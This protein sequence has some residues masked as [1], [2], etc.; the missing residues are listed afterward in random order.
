MTLFSKTISWDYFILE[1][2]CQLQ[3][4]LFIYLLNWALETQKHIAG[5]RR[6]IP[7]QIIEKALYEMSKETQQ[8]SK[9]SPGSGASLAPI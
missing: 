2:L 3:T 7:V 5:Q 9:Q 1:I 4:L 8:E 6:Q